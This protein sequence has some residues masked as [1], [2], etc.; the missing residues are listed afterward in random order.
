MIAAVT[1]LV[2][3]FS[4]GAQPSIGS[5]FTLLRFADTLGMNCVYLEN[6]WGA[7]YLERPADLD[8]YA[9]MFEQLSKTA[10]SADE[11]LQL[12]AKLAAELK[13]EQATGSAPWT[14]TT[15]HGTRAATPTAAAAPARRS[16]TYPAGTAPYEIAR[17]GPGQR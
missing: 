10:L 8:R 2:Q 1:V 3:P 5:A 17:T 4:A 11:S 7:L 14:S 12:I 16:L 9:A 6:D 15:S 13:G